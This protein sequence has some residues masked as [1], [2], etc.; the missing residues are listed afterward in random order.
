ME[1][2]NQIDAEAVKEIGQSVE[3]LASEA[4]K[5][6]LVLKAKKYGPLIN[7]LSKKIETMLQSNS[8]KKIIKTQNT[9]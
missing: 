8:N 7:D 9:F 4:E 2:T 6:F 3:K 1:A 5:D